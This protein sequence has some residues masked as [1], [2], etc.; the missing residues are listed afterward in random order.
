MFSV[1]SK[2]LKRVSCRSVPELLD[3][4]KHCLTGVKVEWVR[5]VVDFWKENA[6]RAVKYQ[7]SK[8]YSFEMRKRNDQQVVLQKL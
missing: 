3:S 4:I 8:W 5:E 7:L 1:I 6:S 2:E